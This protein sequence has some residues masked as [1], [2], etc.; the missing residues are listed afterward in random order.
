[1]LFASTGVDGGLGEDYVAALGLRIEDNSF[2]GV[3]R[4]IALGRSVLH[5][6]ETRIAGNT[7]VGCR[8]AGISLLG[9]A[10]PNAAVN[11]SGNVCIVAGDGIV[12]GLDAAR[13]A[14]NDIRSAD[15]PRADGDGIVLARG[16]DAGGIDHCQIL[17]NRIRGVRG[18][19]IVIRAPVIHCMIKHNIIAESGGG[20]VMENDGEAEALVVEN[21]QLLDIAGNVNAE[22][23]DLA[24]IQ[25]AAVRSLDVAGNAIVGFARGAR[26]SASRAAI[27]TAGIAH[28]RIAGNRMLGIAPANGFMGLGL[29]I[30][31]LAP[32]AALEVSGN[33]VRRRGAD[34]DKIA[35]ARWIPVAIR[36][37]V[38]GVEGR[39]EGFLA[40]GPLAVAMVGARVFVFSGNRVRE[41]AAAASGDASV[42]GNALETEESEESPIHIDGVRGCTLSDNR[43]STIRGRGAPSRVR[44]RRAVVSGN[45]LRGLGDATVLEIALLGKGQAAILGNVRSGDIRLNGSALPPPW[46]VL[47]PYSPE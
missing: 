23:A 18:T 42:R 36:T 14:E 2:W 7:L 41:L 38:G 29:G 4:G 6:G 43:V 1:V 5:F 32:F 13:I 44:C 45:D 17:A 20:I 10:A 24:A 47:N 30:D 27:R 3:N 21:N 26:Q 28:A 19:G 11:V 9:G 40:A 15:E 34:E 39:A 33:D 37:P 8:D 31:V 16:L 35:G 12:C 25:L 46:D 22:G